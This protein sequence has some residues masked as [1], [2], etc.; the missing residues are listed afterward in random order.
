MWQF[1]FRIS[2]LLAVAIF[3]A[4]TGI[5][6]AKAADQYTVEVLVFTASNYAFDRNTTGNEIWKEDSKRALSNIIPQN[7]SA[8][9]PK[10]S[11]NDPI[12]FNTG[13]KLTDYLNLLKQNSNYQILKYISWSQ[14]TLS[15]KRSPKVPFSSA[16]EDDNDLPSEIHSDLEG[17]VKFYLGSFLQLDLNLTYSP[18]SDL[19][20]ESSDDATKD[21]TDLHGTMVR[22]KY[23]IR[24][25]RRVR[26]DEINY[27]DHPMFGVIAMVFPS[28]KKIT[29]K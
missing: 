22:G 3:S 18:Q 24:E 1:N 21:S 10:N 17:S 2:K 26:I 23:T 15:K 13:K 27:F 16:R 4:L 8:K 9:T 25:K 7:K 5:N 28:D 11:K 29:S 6:S 19:N 20:L 12:T 14:P